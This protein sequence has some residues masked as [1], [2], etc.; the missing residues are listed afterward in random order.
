MFT[1]KEN[2]TR[3]VSRISSQIDFNI[4]ALSSMAQIN[5]KINENN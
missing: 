5:K 1:E 2:Q 4:S 3:Y